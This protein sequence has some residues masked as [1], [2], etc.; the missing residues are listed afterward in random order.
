MG[1]LR[2]AAAP[3]VYPA[4]AYGMLAG[5]V[6]AGPPR[7]WRLEHRAQQKVSMST[8]HCRRDAWRLFALAKPL[9]RYLASWFTFCPV[10]IRL[11]DGALSR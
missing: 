1:Q 10:R 9:L 5:P 11:P 2:I 7:P 4:A 3:G 8:L 6:P